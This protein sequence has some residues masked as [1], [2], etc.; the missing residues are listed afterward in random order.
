MFDQAHL[1]EA[2]ELTQAAH[3]QLIRVEQLLM[4]ITTEFGAETVLCG[5]AIDDTNE[6]LARLRKLSGGTY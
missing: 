3:E 6:L 4:S 2:F 1:R 5:V